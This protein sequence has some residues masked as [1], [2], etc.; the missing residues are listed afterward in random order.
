MLSASLDGRGVWWRMDT[1][2]RM[3]KSLTCSPETIT[4][5]LIGYTPI[6]NASGVKK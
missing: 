1:Y 2:I 4:T 6:Q 5:F 3:A